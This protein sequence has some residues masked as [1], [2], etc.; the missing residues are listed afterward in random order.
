M[1]DDAVV[2]SSC[3]DH[4]AAFT[5]IVGTRFFD[6]HMLTGITGQDRGWRMPMNRRRIDDSVDRFVVEDA[7]KII[8]WLGRA[9][10]LGRLSET[11]FVRIG[12]VGN[13]CILARGEYS[14]IVTAPSP[15]S[16]QTDAE[17]LIR[18]SS[19]G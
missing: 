7:S 16:D 11:V 4:Q 19:S 6:I 8:R 15:A 3:L 10:L 12:D 2:P 1:L 18:P 14:G 5:Q 17:T 13:L 9:E